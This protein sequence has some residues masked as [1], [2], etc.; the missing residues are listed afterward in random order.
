V[1]RFIGYSLVVTT[2]NHNTFKI[3]LIVTHV[4]SHTKSSQADFQSF[5]NYELPVA[6]SYRQLTLSVKVTLRLEVYRPS[7]RLGVRPL[8]AH[9]QRFFSK[10][11]LAVIVLM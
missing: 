4:K 10:R 6:M 9:D 3:T 11:T 7:V 8:E 1:N 5:F 2:N